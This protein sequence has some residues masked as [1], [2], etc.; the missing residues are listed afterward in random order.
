MGPDALAATPGERED[1]V[2]LMVWCPSGEGLWWGGD[3]MTM[4]DVVWGI[5]DA[6]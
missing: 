1:P 3:S 4:G 2:A 6:V 5:G